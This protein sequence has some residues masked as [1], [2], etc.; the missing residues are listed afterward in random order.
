LNNPDE[1][2]KNLDELEKMH[3]SSNI[4]KDAEETGMYS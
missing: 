2:I 4:S 3:E 1:A